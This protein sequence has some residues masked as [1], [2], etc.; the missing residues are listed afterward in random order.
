M[1][2]KILVIEDE[3]SIRRFLK[4]SLEMDGYH[5][6]E[7]GGVEEAMRLV[8]RERPELVILDLVL[9]DGDGLGVLKSIRSWSKLPIVVLTVRDDEQ[10]KVGILDAG[11]DDYLTKPFSVPELLARL[12]AVRRRQGQESNGPI[13]ETG[14]LRVD[15]VGHVV[16]LGDEEV[17]LTSTEFNI[18]KLLIKHAGKV[19][20]HRQILKE[21]W[22]DNCVE[23]TQ[24]IRVYVGH[25]RKKIEPRPDAIRLI[26]TEP[27][28]GYRLLVM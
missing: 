21:V 25:L 1:K 23:Q 4:I 27:G 6:I 14:P 8:T 5:V 28:V 20:L 15:L 24:Y 11:A 3:D 13:F 2:T 17:H 18:L 12:R 7:A 10:T 16:M 26:V 22:G 9:P 19:V